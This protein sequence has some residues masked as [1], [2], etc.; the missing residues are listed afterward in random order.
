MKAT[1][2]AAS[3]RSGRAIARAVPPIAAWDLRLCAN[4]QVYE[5]AW[6]AYLAQHLS[7][8]ELKKDEVRDTLAHGADAV[9]S[10][11]QL[12]LY[13]LLAALLVAV[14]IFGWQTYTERQT[15]KATA[16][17]DDA[18][19]S[20]QARIRTAG[21][22]AQPSET[23][24][25]DEKNKY[26]DA[27]QKFAAVN[28]K[29]GHTRPGQLAAY[30]AAL[31][32]EKLDKNDEAKKWLQGLSESGVEDFAAIARFE[33]AQLN[34]RMGQGDE[35][36]KLYQQLIAKPVVLVPK[37][38]VML[39]LAEHYGAKNPAEATKL[40]TQIKSDYPDTPI[41]EQ[42]TQEMNLLPGKS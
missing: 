29:Y 32:D 3:S 20:F 39:A 15:V 23:T 7:R 1:P 9:L 13:I 4:I 24:Y 40:Y 37:P 22:P 30:Y 14:G 2:S 38:V 18:M 17:Y 6:G 31:S 34:D 33:L 42:A 36:V 16:A 8:R 25:I 5:F 21:E 35:A 12:T 27:A 11:K 41:A 10:H 26:S 28:A 19:K